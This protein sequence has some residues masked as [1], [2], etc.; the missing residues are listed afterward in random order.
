MDTGAKFLCIG[1]SGAGKT[2][3]MFDILY[4]LVKSGSIDASRIVIYSKTVKSDPL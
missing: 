2:H 4:Y 3:L 1:R